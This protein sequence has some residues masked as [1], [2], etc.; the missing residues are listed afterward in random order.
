[1]DES[2]LFTRKYHRGRRLRHQFW[3][4]GGISRLTRK[5]FVVQIKDKRRATLFPLMQEHIAQGTY[6]MTDDLLSYR[7]CPA[8]G[9]TGHSSVTHARMFVGRRRA[10]IPAGNPALGFA[11]AGFVRAKVHTSTLERSWRFL[12]SFLRT[13]RRP[14]M[15][16]NYIGEYLY[17]TNVIRDVPGGFGHQLLH[18]LYD[19]GRVYPGLTGNPIQ[20]EDCECEECV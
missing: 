8:L 10:R 2:H 18:F 16:P 19:V 13:C 17:R 12:K 14:R 7:G 5:R 9:F 3:V 15:I 4:F 1:V 11:G 6:I 20:T